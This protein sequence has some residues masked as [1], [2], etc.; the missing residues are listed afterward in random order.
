MRVKLRDSVADN[1]N[2]HSALV[3]AQGRADRL[4]SETVLAMQARAARKHSEVKEE[5]MAEDVPE[6]EEEES[7]PSPRE[8]SGLVNWWEFTFF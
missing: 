2:L 8:V 1:E 7:L 5:E 4:Q 6:P 3:A